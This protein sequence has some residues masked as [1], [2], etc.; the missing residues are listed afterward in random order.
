MSTTARTRLV[1][2]RH[3]VDEVIAD[4]RLRQVEQVGQQQPIRRLPVWDDVAIGIRRLENDQ[5]VG[6]VHAFSNAA[7]KRIGAL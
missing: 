3:R 2:H 7:W 4:Q 5:I 1:G 6:D